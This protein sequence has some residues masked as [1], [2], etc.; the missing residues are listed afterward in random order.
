MLD[1]PKGETIERLRQCV[2]QMRTDISEHEEDI[3]LLRDG[4]KK[5]SAVIEIFNRRKRAADA[6]YGLA[7]SDALSEYGASR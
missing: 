3:A 2:E 4:I 7:Y 5:I 6:E 1:D